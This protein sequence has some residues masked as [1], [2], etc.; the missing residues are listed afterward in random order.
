MTHTIILKERRA[1]LVVK[2][3]SNG[4]KIVSEPNQ[5]GWVKVEVQIDRDWDAL[6]LFHA[7]IEAR[8][9]LEEEIRN[10]VAI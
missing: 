2:E 6:S 4:T 9:Q 3:M 1:Q 5:E 10:G 8:K 7:G